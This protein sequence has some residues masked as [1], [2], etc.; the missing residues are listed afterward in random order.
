MLLLNFI[1]AEALKFEKQNPDN[2]I[3]DHDTVIPEWGRSYG[4]VLLV[5]RVSGAD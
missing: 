3:S 2:E 5:G 4:A 1:S